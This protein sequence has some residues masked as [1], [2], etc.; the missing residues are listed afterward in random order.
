MGL[1]FFRRVG[2]V[3]GAVPAARPGASQYTIQTN[4]TLLDDD[5]CAFFKQHNFLV[6]LS[7]DG[8]RALHDAYRVDKG[9][10]PTFD[11][12]MRG[13]A[14]LQQHGVDFNILTTVHAANADQPARRLPLLPRRAAGAQFIQFIPIVE[15]A[16]PRRCPG[17]PGLERAPRQ[18]R[19]RYT[20]RR[21]PGHRPLGDAGAVRAVS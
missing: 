3:R 9:G 19:G 13:W 21:A 6:G 14:L 17:Q 10:Q 16:T 11:R 1:D 18:R 7:I 2:G 12:V 20:P 8:P 4:G 15:R 5:W